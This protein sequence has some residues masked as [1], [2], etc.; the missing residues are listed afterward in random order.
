M[1]NV[2]GNKK[3]EG[4]RGRE[5]KKGR[6]QVRGR[7]MGKRMMFKNNQMKWIKSIKS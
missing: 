1:K 3:C 6:K 7:E 5:K 2:K 4:K